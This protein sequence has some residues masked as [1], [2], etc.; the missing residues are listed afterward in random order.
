MGGGFSNI[1]FKK[2]D[3]GTEY[4][5]AQAAKDKKEWNDRC[6]EAFDKFKQFMIKPRVLTIPFVKNTDLLSFTLS[7]LAG[8]GAFVCLALSYLESDFMSLRVYAASGISLSIIFQYYREKPLWIPI[9][10]NALFLTIN[11]IMIM[12]LLKDEN[13]AKQ[14]PE[15]QKQIYERVFQS[16]GMKPVDFLHLMS[17][18][19][20]VCLA[21]GQKIVVEGEIHDHIHLVQSGSFKVT[22]SHHAG[23]DESEPNIYDVVGDV[24]ANQFVGEMAFLR[25]VSKAKGMKKSYDLVG[26]SINV[27]TEYAVLPYASG[28]GLAN[29]TGSQIGR[30]HV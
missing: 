20:R 15:E 8:H 1:G 22:Q 24:Q 4:S 10:W 14:I 16:K 26:T 5:E 6:K 7:N 19:R 27:I 23:V 3:K 18:A 30:A 11:A 17:R 29:G 9:R 13:A 2:G 25:Y 12:L 28:A 21:K